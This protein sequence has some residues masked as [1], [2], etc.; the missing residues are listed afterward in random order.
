MEGGRSPRPDA[1]FGGAVAAGV[2]GACRALRHGAAA[3]GIRNRGTPPH[4][5]GA[6]A[7]GRRGGRGMPAR[8]RRVGRERRSGCARGPSLALCA[9]VGLA[10]ADDAAPGLRVCAEILAL[11]APA[12]EVVETWRGARGVAF[13]YRIDDAEDDGLHRLECTLAETEPGRLRAS[14]LREDGRELSEAELVLVNS[15][16][17]LAEIR[18]ADPGPPRTD[19]FWSGWLA[20]LRPSR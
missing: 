5:S 4:G 8:R 18:R 6:E 10:C 11:R 3:A 15:E 20:R 1:E 19:P 13:D 7:A 9:L 16:L 14:A 12:A 17:L 2:R